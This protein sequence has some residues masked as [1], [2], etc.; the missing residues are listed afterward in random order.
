MSVDVHLPPVYIKDIIYS[1]LSSGLLQLSMSCIDMPWVPLYNNITIINA[2]SNEH[3]QKYCA[4]P[5]F[6]WNEF[7]LAKDLS[8]ICT[9]LVGPPTNQPTSSVL[10]GSLEMIDHGLWPGFLLFTFFFLNMHVKY[11]WV[12]TALAWLWVTAFN[13]WQIAWSIKTTK[14]Y[15]SQLFVGTFGWSTHSHSFSRMEPQWRMVDH[16]P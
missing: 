15:Y 9:F 10:G 4:C 14:M 8:K 16:R 5:Y 3:S 13:N 11:W 2:T 1:P 12:A 7:L 6:G